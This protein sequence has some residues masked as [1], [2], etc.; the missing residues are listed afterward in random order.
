MQALAGPF[1]DLALHGSGGTG[2]VQPGLVGAAAEPHRDRLASVAG[3]AVSLGTGPRRRRI[4]DRLRALAAH[5]RRTSLHL[6]GTRCGGHGRRRRRRI[7][8]CGGP[9]VAVIL[10][11]GDPAGRG[12]RGRAGGRRRRACGCCGRYV[13]AGAGRWRRWRSRPRVHGQLLLRRG[14]HS[15][16]KGRVADDRGDAETDQGESRCRSHQLDPAGRESTPDLASATSG[17]GVGRVA[18]ELVA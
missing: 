2:S 9:V 3:A 10:T 12:N 16:P 18:A 6:E 5:R 17:E 14:A 11:R 15:E 1:L 7:G 8:R 4:Q 13:A